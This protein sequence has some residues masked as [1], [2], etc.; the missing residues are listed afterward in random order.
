MIPATKY[1]LVHEFQSSDTGKGKNDEAKG[2][3]A[4]GIPSG[5]QRREGRRAGT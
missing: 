2:M 1:L 4:K 3:E 5:G